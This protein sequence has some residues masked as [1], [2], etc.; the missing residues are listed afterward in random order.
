MTQRLLIVYNANAGL[1][2][3]ALDTLHKIVSPATY[4][5][6]LCG[7]TYGLTGMR[8]EWRAFL[9]ELGLETV[10]HHRPDFRAAW[11]QAA[12]W[13]L[14]LVALERDGVLTQLVAAADFAGANDLPALQSL[15]AARLLSANQG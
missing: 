3:G 15:L 8:A 11:P 10:F 13:S 1:V 2:A 4:P 12:N 7:I 14:P 5:C 6:A 9:A